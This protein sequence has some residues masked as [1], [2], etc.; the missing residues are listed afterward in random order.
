MSRRS[1]HYE[2]HVRLY[3]H[4]LQSEAY[5]SLSPDARAMLIE[6]R[7]LYDGRENR[8]YLSRREMQRRLGIG[9][10]RVENARDDLEERGF[11]RLLTKGTFSRKD[12]HASE[13]ELTNEPAGNKLA[14]KDF[15]RWRP[16]KNTGLAVNHVGA[17]EQ[18]REH[19]P[20][21]RKQPDGAGEQP[22]EGNK[23]GSHGAGDQPTDKLPPEGGNDWLSENMGWRCRNG[24]LLNTCCLVCGVWITANGYEFNSRKHSCD[25]VSRAMYGERIGKADAFARHLPQSVTPLQASIGAGFRD[26]ASV[27]SAGRVTDRKTPKASTGAVC[28]A[29]TDKE[30]EARA[31]RPCTA[32]EYRALRGAE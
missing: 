15:M 13:Y 9:R 6:F 8:V 3:Q 7:A 17:G 28:N 21:S 19:S 32:S 26:F 24:S 2:S 10:T 11:I 29:V 16:Q 30:P 18:P 1:K 20:R 23:P 5:R 27:T 12:R 14:S 31:P 25:P 4:E 22:R